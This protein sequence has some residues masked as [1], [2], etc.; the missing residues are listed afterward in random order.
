MNKTLKNV[1]KYGVILSIMSYLL[2]NTF[3]GIPEEALQ[4]G[5]SRF[6]FVLSYWTKSSKPLLLLSVL[7]AVLSHVIRAARWNI[8]L[9]PLGYKNVSLFNSFFAVMNGYFINLFVPRGGEL[10][11]PFSLEKTDGVPTDVGVGTVVT[12]RIVDLIFLALCIGSA[13]LFQYDV[14]TSFL[15]EAWVYLEASEDPN[16][17]QGISKLAILGIIAGVGI[18]G[19]IGLFILKK[20][21]FKMLKEKALEFVKGMIDG[22]LSIFKLE[23]WGLYIIYSIMIWVFY[24]LMPVSYTHLTLP[25]IA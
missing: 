15:E 5:G 25:T 4:D 20:D 11:R 1:L 21:L 9:E 13:F 16:A 7:I 8:A 19:V 12:E 14:I 10:S 23:K 6:D 24:Y 17:E 3:M 2:Y 18:V 22:V